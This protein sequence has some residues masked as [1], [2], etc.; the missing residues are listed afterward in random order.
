MFQ[1][2]AVTI[3]REQLELWSTT[4][5]VSQQEL[6]KEQLTSSKLREEVAAL[7]QECQE[8]GTSRAVEI[9]ELPA[10]NLQ[11]L[12]ASLHELQERNERL[13]VLQ[14]KNDA[15][16]QTVATERTRYEV[17]LERT[18][19]RNLEEI[20]K[21][22][23]NNLKE[24]AASLHEL[25]DRNERLRELHLKN[26]ELEAE[27]TLEKRSKAEALERS[28][29]ERKTPRREEQRSGSV[30][31]F[32][33]LGCM[34]TGP[35]PDYPG[36]HEISAPPSAVA[37]IHSRERPSPSPRGWPTAVRCQGVRAGG[38]LRGQPRVGRRG[39]AR[40]VRGA[41]ARR[42][43][44][45][46]SA[47]RSLAA[48]LW[49]RPVSGAP[50]TEGTARGSGHAAARSPGPREVVRP[51][52]CRCEVG[53]AYPMGAAWSASEVGGGACHHVW[54]VGTV[55]R[56]VASVWCKLTRAAGA[57]CAGVSDRLRSEASG[58]ACG[59]AQHGFHR[60][61]AAGSLAASAAPRSCAARAFWL[62]LRWGW[63]AVRCLGSLGCCAPGEASGCFRGTEWT[64]C[65][66][67]GAAAWLPSRG[68][69]G[70]V[71]TRRR[72]RAEA[73]LQSVGARACFE[74]SGILLPWRFHLRTHVLQPAPCAVGPFSCA[75]EWVRRRC[76]PR[77]VVRSVALRVA[78]RWPRGSAGYLVDPAS[79]HM[80]VSK[81]KPC[82]SKYKRLVL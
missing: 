5:Q 59:P 1:E 60:L 3:L 68:L 11:E 14:L 33:S 66:G 67:R 22:Q 80:L 27:L 7:R 74:A 39:R 32:P 24:L 65:A 23:A 16:E 44:G 82:M 38:A 4:A 9:N 73:L 55:S 15:L 54:I 40:W 41:R 6:E 31:Q 50:R 48:P 62:G 35:A 78:R 58:A 36:T 13:R 63:G 70:G 52:S 19:A 47:R 18:E 21:M 17:Q 79:S 28:P 25:Q 10:K 37:S 64:L 57:R 81:I 30:G 71:A 75:F 76:F 56:R 12:S 51:H 46:E 29:E 26:A 8:A 42:G 2:E 49:T 45:R 72:A 43:R 77:A 34:P 20:N 69:C 61:A 53:G